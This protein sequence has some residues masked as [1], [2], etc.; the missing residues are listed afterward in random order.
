MKYLRIALFIT[1]ILTSVLICHAQEIGK[2]TAQAA[3]LLNFV[4]NIEW[5]N[6][7][8]FKEFKI[9]LLGSDKT[10]ISE[11]NKAAAN[12]KIRGKS[13]K[14]INT[15]NF[16]DI[17]NSHIVFIMKE[18]ESELRK[19]FD[20]TEGK[21][22]LLIT[23]N[24]TDK[25]LIMI[26]FYTNANGNLLFEIN[27]ANILNQKL[28]IMHD[29]ILLGGTEIDVATIYRE[30]QQSLRNLQK[31]SEAL[32][33]T[34]T[35][36]TQTLNQLEKEIKAGSIEAKALR[37]SI[38]PLYESIILQKKT[39][40]DQKILL[41]ARE[42]E[43]DLLGS[44]IEKQEN[45]YKSQSELIKDQ[46][47]KISDGL[48][49]LKKQEEQLL[50]QKSELK[51]QDLTLNTQVKTIDRQKNLVIFM[52]IITILIVFL[53]F[54][55]YYNYREK[56]RHNRE[57]EHRVEQRTQEIMALNQTLESRVN[58]RTAQLVS[59]NKELESFSYSI[60]H[61]LRAPLRA[62]FGFSQI[63]IRRH[64]EALN[65]EG[66]QYLDYIVE[67]SI[68]M[69][70]LINDLLNYSRLGRK[71]IDIVKIDLNKIVSEIK[72]DFSQKF[73]ELNVDFIAD[74]DFPVVKGDESL[75][76]QVLTNLVENA[77][78][79]RK[80]DV[81]PIVRI[82]TKPEN[83]GITLFIEDNGIGI[84][85]EYWDK[86]FNIFQR[87]HSDDEIPGTGI[88]LATV[89]KAVSKMNGEINVKSVVGEGS[90]FIIN[91]SS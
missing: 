87:L 49:I 88:G 40:A 5:N 10:L 41:D 71:P 54:A 17:E 83:N 37:D 50:K 70:K 26:N 9:L 35:I 28:K 57:L 52:L 2:Q 48:I 84:P 42:N 24:F 78:N 8:D 91:L 31:H 73:E 75:M 4:R 62:I 77:V 39:L 30:G 82:Y 72:D 27:K 81:K 61:D 32:E 43:I 63:L 80:K 22:T 15:G 53:F 66:K 3:Y 6:E 33:S 20:L 19:I 89:K 55:I 85:E 21:N 16:S 86:I 29:L 47:K 34:L 51:K 76:R 25:R 68:R 11:L 46:Q 45:T 44:E 74:E 59:I 1:T 58:E 14:I 64:K 36:Q 60:S 12:R 18:Y 65:D 23:D 67:A 7:N 90:T 69:E 13:F 38:K 56:K 79:Y